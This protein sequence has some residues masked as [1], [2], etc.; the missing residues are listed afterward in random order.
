M[1]LEDMGTEERLRSK[2]FG[3]ASARD[4]RRFLLHQSRA[5]NS[6]GVSTTSNERGLSAFLGKTFHDRSEAGR[7]PLAAEPCVKRGGDLELETA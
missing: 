6:I 4:P 5:T 2:R 7:A 1:N 3:I